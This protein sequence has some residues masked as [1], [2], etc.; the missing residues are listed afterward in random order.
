VSTR[1]DELGEGPRW[2]ADREE[3]VSVDI[4]PGLM[5]RQCWENG[6]L[7]ESG[8]TALPAPLGCVAP[9]DD[10]G[11]LAVTGD[12]VLLESRRWAALATLEDV[13]ADRGNDS[14]GGVR[15]NDGAC[16][17]DGDLLV[18]TMARNAAAGSGALWR[19][20]ADGRARKLRGGCTIPNGIGWSPDGELM[21]WTDTSEGWI[22][23]YRY[24]ECQ[25]SLPE[26]E[27]R[28]PVA[29]GSPDGLCVDAEGHL[30]VALWGAGAVIRLTPEGREVQRVHVPTGQP[31]APCLG[32]PELRTLFITSAWTGVD[33]RAEPLAGAIF[34]VEVDVPGMLP[35]S[36]R[37][38][39]PSPS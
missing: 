15:P 16:G 9:S 24:E 5:H 30:W 35:H 27:R 38:S 18:G 11:W 10:G 33:R 39:A 28:L 14:E 34:A 32:G 17:P 4:L 22:G 2:D 25:E 19:V 13:A 23:A 1:R 29:D 7:V 20:T 8:T 26:P 3:L 31:T 6:A 37:T 21:W 12:G 36:L